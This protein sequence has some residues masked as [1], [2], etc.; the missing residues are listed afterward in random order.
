MDW[1]VIAL[2]VYGVCGIVAGM[3]Y[4]SNSRIIRRGTANAFAG[5][6]AVVALWLLVAL[7]IGYRR[8]TRKRRLARADIHD[9]VTRDPEDE[10]WVGRAAMGTGQG[11][12]RT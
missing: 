3:W 9:L 10:H 5:G 6:I 11:R 8:L 12:G 2:V 1:K 7:W 4:V